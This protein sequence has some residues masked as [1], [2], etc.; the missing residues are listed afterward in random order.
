MVHRDLKPANVLVTSAGRV[1]VLDLGVAAPWGQNAGPSS[2][3][4]VGTPSYMPPEQALGQDPVPASDAWALGC[5]LSESMTGVRGWGAMWGAAA[6]SAGAFPMERPDGPDDLVELSMRLRAWEPTDRMTLEAAAEV[7]GGAAAVSV[8]GW[9]PLREP[10]FFDREDERQALRAQIDGDGPSLVIVQGEAG[11]GKSAVVREVLRVVQASPAHV[12]VSGRCDDAESVPFRAWDGVVDALSERLLAM[13]ATEVEAISLRNPG[14]LFSAFP[15]LGR[16]PSFNADTARAPSVAPIEWQKEAFAG[17]VDLLEQ[18]GRLRRVVIAI[19]DVAEGDEDSARL[20]AAVL[21]SPSLNAAVVLIGRDG[22]ASPLLAAIRAPHPAWCVLQ[23][24]VGPLATTDAAAMLVD[25]GVDRSRPDFDALVAQADGSPFLLTEL[26]QQARDGWT[27]R[28]IDEAIRLR[29]STLDA[30]AR[31]LLVAASVCA[32]PDGP[33]FLGAVAGLSAGVREAV[34][35]LRRLRLLR[36]VAGV[37]RERVEPHHDRVAA[38]VL[39]ELP[40]DV[41]SRLHDRAAELLGAR[42][43]GEPNRR[44]RHLVGAGKVVEAAVCAVEAG[45]LALEALA[46][47]AAVAL[48]GQAVELEP[49]VERL[50]LLAEALRLAGRLS[51]SGAALERAACLVESGDPRAWDLHRGAG[52]A[53]L[54]AGDLAQGLAVLTPLLEQVG[55][56]LPATAGAATAEGLWL[57]IRFMLFGNLGRQGASSPT[58][59]STRRMDLLWSVTTGLSMLDPA[60]GDVLGLRHLLDAGRQGDP[61]RRA[62][63][64]GFEASNEALV[65]NGFFLGRARALLERAEPLAADTGLPADR[66]WVLLART[67]VHGLAGEFRESAQLGLEAE[68]LYVGECTGVDWELMA[69]R[70]YVNGALA[71]LGEVRLLQDRVVRGLDDALRREHVLAAMVHRAGQPALAWLWLDRPEV[72]LASEA[73]PPESPGVDFSALRYFSMVAT[74]RA[75]LYSGDPT[76]ARAA[77]DLSWAGMLAAGYLGFAYTRVEMFV[78]RSQVQAASGE[79]AGLSSAAGRIAKDTPLAHAAAYAAL[80]RAL[81]AP[82]AVTFAAAGEAFE[83]REL[84]VSAAACRWRAARLDGRMADAETII[85]TARASGIVNPERYFVGFAPV[86]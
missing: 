1:V 54:R 21:R 5:I 44:L 29:V 66:A 15:V 55:V 25:L 18:V 9:A 86:A 69:L 53:W 57:R 79:L 60:R 26:A 27:V 13:R 43:G 81:A 30:D 68:R 67:T 80:V 51:E 56:R 16:V 50:V 20:L 84:A 83:A 40:R 42:P 64:L 70:T 78:L 32:A 3:T 52:E 8:S 19:D 14:A 41:L 71:Q 63:A 11:R 34:Y 47:E 58:P 85:A 38:V 2:V 39:A 31:A 62:R 6:M 4:P 61:S 49:T 48:Y 82:S 73:L 46:F 37:P 72:I 35:R 76:G 24:N 59:D 12:V 17:F 33:D 10:Q 65:G 77:L 36:S 75:R 45:G 7:L 74:V 22:A 23:L 28:S